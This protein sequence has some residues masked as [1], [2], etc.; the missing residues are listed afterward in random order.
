M[1][2]KP[3]R[4]SCRMAHQASCS[5]QSVR[6]IP[7]FFNGFSD[8]SSF[9]HAVRY[10]RRPEPCPTM[11]SVKRQTEPNPIIPSPCTKPKKKTQF[12]PPCTK[13][14]KK[15]NSK[16]PRATE[17][18]MAGSNAQH[19]RSLAV[20][21]SPSSFRG[22]EATQPRFGKRLS[23]VSIGCRMWAFARGPFFFFHRVSNLT[24]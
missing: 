22:S 9:F 3:R 15:L 21:G 19:V 16:P 13:P 7:P 2:L 10:G 8:P 1:G 5:M 11:C 12:K 20:S 14:K 6:C 18:Q 17:P 24:T 23:S 4:I